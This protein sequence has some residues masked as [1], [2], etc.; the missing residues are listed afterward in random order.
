MEFRDFRLDSLAFVPCMPCRLAR[1][2]GVLILWLCTAT[3][4]AAQLPR[5]VNGVVT[6]SSGQALAGATIGVVGH[7]A[8]T[9]SG[10]DG[11]FTLRLPVGKNR[12]RVSQVGYSSKIVTILA[13]GG[14]V[15]IRLVPM[16][17]FLQGLTI[18]APR[19]PPMAQTVTAAT[20]S[21]VPALIEPDV[22]RAVTLL[23]GVSQPN[24]LT[25]RIHLAGGA[26]DET[27][28][29][30]DGHPLQD[31]FH[32]LG[33]F[34]AVPIG[35]LGRADVLMHHLPPS[36]GNHL[37]GVIDLHTKRA[38]SRITGE[39]AVS[40]LSASATTALPPSV[41]GLDL[42][43]SGRVTYIDQLANRVFPDAPHMGF[44][45]ALVRVGRNWSSWRAEALAFRTQ[46]HYAA[47]DLVGLAG[48]EPMRWGETLV[49]VRTSGAIGAW[50]MSARASA[51]VAG[52][53][54]D[55]GTIAS[56]SVRAI[57]NTFV[58]T[59][60]D[61]WSG[62]LEVARHSE[63]LD[64][65]VGAAVDNRRNRQQWL[66]EGLAAEIFS[67]HTP[68]EYEG[69]QKLL[70]LN[71]F[72]EVTGHLGRRWNVSLGSR[73][74]GTG[75]AYVA[76][77]ALVTWDASDRIRVEA[78]ADR[79]HQWDAQ[80]E[81][82]IEGSVSPPLF[83]LD[84]P[85]TVDVFALAT[86]VRGPE[87]TADRSWELNLL[88]FWKNYA[89][90][91][92][93][94][95]SDRLD[96][97]Q[98]VPF[99]SFDLIEGYGIGLSAGGR[100]RLGEKALV[101]GSYTFQRVTDVPDGKR[102]PTTWDVPHTLSLLGSMELGRWIMSITYQGHSGRATTPVIARSFE[103]FLDGFSSLRP[104]Y[105]RGARN[106]IRVPAYHRVDVGGRR[107]WKVRRVEIALRLQVLNVLMHENAI[108]YDWQ[109]YFFWLKGSGRERAGRYGLP[110][111][112]SIGVEVR[113]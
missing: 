2:A 67:P 32:L 69:N 104:R 61:W 103:P 93:L 78:A 79:R 100:V 9:L 88:A 53:H 66:A 10:V 92:R 80:L 27:G 109:Q 34:G 54:L 42:L 108:D 4:A 63:G 96:V 101:Q 38:P 21:Q 17:V 71:L 86:R 73:V 70:L 33:L 60:R 8:S 30:L 46:D 19:A 55:E 95:V 44:S 37:S 26:S 35:I 76:P 14:R 51:N 59:E 97:G 15:V 105:I 23:P 102:M 110:I 84:K 94:R 77:R 12:L 57:H 81:E 75:N 64:I 41:A 89:N 72:G 13:V 99:P 111:L 40:V 28:I 29:L 49:G 107:S 87:S 98:E 11:T 65:A 18:E 83:L 22:F 48:Y 16:P 47:A 68:G 62:A 31:P 113:W 20:V 24:D 85:R 36:I 43:V 39:A 52:I 5:T 6:D 91:P 25:G 45:D 56:D 112:P 7:Q 82:P 58:D 3:S 90:Q 106:S 1:H 50:T 74:S